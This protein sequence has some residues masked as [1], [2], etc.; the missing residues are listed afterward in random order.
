MRGGGKHLPPFRIRLHRA[1][2]GYTHFADAH[3]V[4]APE[5]VGCI[6]AEAMNCV[7]LILQWLSATLA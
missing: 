7:R 4:E 6:I 2:S 3:L 5:K 1:I